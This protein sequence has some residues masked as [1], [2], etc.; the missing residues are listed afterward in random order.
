MSVLIRIA[1]RP[2]ESF[3]LKSKA[4]VGSVTCH[5]AQQG[6][7]RGQV[8]GMAV[9]PQLLPLLLLLVVVVVV[10]GTRPSS[11]GPCSLRAPAGP[12]PQPLSMRSSL[13]RLCWAWPRR[14]RRLPHQSA[15][16]PSAR[17]AWQGGAR[18]PAAT[19]GH[20]LP[21]L[22]FLLPVVAQARRTWR[23]RMKKMSRGLG[24]LGLLLLLLGPRRSLLP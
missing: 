18:W 2:R 5:G 11:G 10:L 3:P 23:G 24:D 9:P 20:H 7:Q 6:A 12:S 17:L 22:P 1:K 15:P 19:M 4:R 8:E 13:M 14:L 21:L 16:L